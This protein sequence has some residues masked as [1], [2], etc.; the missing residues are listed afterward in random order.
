MLQPQKGFTQNIRLK[1]N[2]ALI[3]IGI[4]FFVFSSCSQS[5]YVQNEHNQ[6]YVETID[7]TFFVKYISIV[8]HNNTDKNIWL[9]SE[10]LINNDSLNSYKSSFRKLNEKTTVKLDLVKIDTLKLIKASFHPDRVSG[11][12]YM[13]NDVIFWDS[14][15]VKHDIYFSPQ[16]KDIYLLK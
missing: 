2:T 8:L 3:L 4:L 13:V 16:L 9:L 1:S 15:T 7:T 6:Y 5:Y 11:F 10:K 12:M 14:D